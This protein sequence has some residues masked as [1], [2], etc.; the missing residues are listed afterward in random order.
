MCYEKQREVYRKYIEPYRQEFIRFEF[1]KQELIPIIELTQKIVEEKQKELNHQI[2][3]LNT[4]KRFMTGLIG[5]LAIERLLGIN[6]IDYEQKANQTHSKHFNTPDLQKANLNLGVKSV[7]YG[8]VPLIPAHNSYSQIICIRDTP[9]SVLVCG[10]ATKEVLNIYQDED[11]VLSTKL[12]EL[13]DLKRSQNNT[14]NIKTGFY[15]FHKLIDIKL[16][17]EKAA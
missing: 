15:G 9:N 16:S 10:L 11:L 12:K 3:D 13:N 4:H 14:N 5:E 2:D 8:K 7:E 17:I 6:I 1:T